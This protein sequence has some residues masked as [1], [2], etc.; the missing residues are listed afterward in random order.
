MKTNNYIKAILFLLI[1]LSTPAVAAPIAS[2]RA[3][4]I[5]RMTSPASLKAAQELMMATFTEAV[6]GKPGFA[7]QKLLLEKSGACISQIVEAQHTH[8][9]TPSRA[10]ELLSQNTKLLNNILQHNQN[11]IA[12]LQE[13]SLDGMQDTETFF[14]SNAWQHPQHLISLA[15]YWQSW[16][17]YYRAVL[18]DNAAPERTEILDLARQGFSRAFIDFQEHSIVIRSLF[19]RMLCYKEGGNYDSAMQDAD[20][21]LTMTSP[22]DSLYVRCRYEQLLIAY[23]RSACAIVTKG[24]K[25]FRNDIAPENISPT[26]ARGLKTL[27]VQC[28]IAL[29]EDAEKK[30]AASSDNYRKVLKEVQ[31]LYAHEPAQAP[32]LYRFVEERPEFFAKLPIAE[33]GSIGN[34]A[35][36]DQLFKQQLWKQ[37]AERYTHV[38]ASND[39]GIKPRRDEILF[40]QAYCMCKLENW[41]QAADFFNR[42]F[43]AHPSSKLLGQAA[44]FYYVA[45]AQVYHTDKNSKNYTRYI[46]SIKRYL[47]L[48]SDQQDACEAHYQ[49]GSYYLEQGKETAALQQFEL[50]KP[51]T[52]RY[53]QARFHVARARVEAFE[54]Q[55]AGAAHSSKGQKAHRQTTQL[56]KKYAS[57]IQRSKLE[58]KAQLSAYVNTLLARLL[59]NGPQPDY[60]GALKLLR[61]TPGDTD[62]QNALTATGLR[63]ECYQHLGATNEALREIDTC[64]KKNQL[65]SDVWTLLQETAGRLY[66]TSKDLRSKQDHQAS[67]YAATALHIYTLLAREARRSSTHAQYLDALNLRIAEINRDENRTETAQGLY[68]EQLA[69]DSSSGDALY[70]LALI[71]EQ[72]MK[73]DQAVATWRKLTRGLEPG[74]PRW[75]EARIHTITGLK[76]LGNIKQACD[77]ATMTLVLHPD[78]P[79]PEAAQTFKQLRDELCGPQAVQ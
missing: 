76:A 38:L 50:I 4:D 49:L 75:L 8:T 48:C 36:A 25:S 56:I 61:T 7:L 22:T 23:Q 14:K 11:I 2:V 73:W 43:K 15:G 1:S 71:Y 54:L 30:G 9:I 13:N 41:E 55:Y 27:G 37:A 26:I 20:T 29:I 57:E 34:L 59:M 42:L 44:C 28:G 69:R 24:I 33:L 70:N 79:D 46:F 63:I 32:I 65:N 72:Q 39:A 16:N 40:H 5:D 78:I 17:G 12:D 52:P 58:N 67:N 35:L 45:A 74:T 64:I 68:E 66:A 10:L 18:M 3:L 62:S 6:A 47:K 19:G 31:K 53:L 77:Y 21:L 60:A 51:N